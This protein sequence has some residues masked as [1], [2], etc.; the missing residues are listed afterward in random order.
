MRLPWN[1]VRL[2]L[3]P[4]R[5]SFDTADA[6]ETQG[7]EFRLPWAKDRSSST[8]RALSASPI[9]NDDICELPETVARILGESLLFLRHVTLA[10]VRRNG[11]LVASY[12]ATRD[13]ATGRLD[14]DVRPAGRTS[15]WHVLHADA[16]QRMARLCERFATL[17][18]L[19]RST[20]VTVAIPVDQEAGTTGRFFA[21]LPTEQQHG[22][23]AHINADFFPKLD[24]KAIVLDGGQHQQAWN[25]VLIECAAA[26]L[27][28][29]LVALREHLAPTQLWKLISDAY[30]TAERAT[31]GG[32]PPELSAFRKAIEAAL[33]RHPPIAMDTLGAWWPARELLHTRTELEADEVSALRQIGVKLI[34]PSL[35]EY[36]DVLCKAGVSLL[37]ARSLA[38][39][40]EDAPV[41]EELSS[42]GRV[43]S[44]QRRSLLE[45]LWRTMD[46]FL[47]RPTSSNRPLSSAPLF[48]RH[49]HRLA[50]FEQGRRRPEGASLERLAKWFPSLPLPH[51]S[52]EEHIHTLS[53]AE[54]LEPELVVSELENACRP[55]GLTTFL[56]HAEPSELR[57]F[58]RLLRD[59]MVGRTREA[60]PQTLAALAVLPIF[61]SGDGYVAAQDAF[62]PGDF[63]DPVGVASLLAKE[64]YDSV[65]QEFLQVHLGVRKQSIEIYV[66]AQ[67]PI[68]FADPPPVEK[69]K[70]LL[71]VLAD[72]SSSLLAAPNLKSTLREIRMIPVRDGGWAVPDRTYKHTEELEKLIGFGPEWW[73]DEE[74]TPGTRAT[75][76]FLLDLGVRDAPC[77]EHLLRTLDELTDG[78][79]TEEVRKQAENLFYVICDNFSRWEEEDGIDLE[80]LRQYESEP[81]FPADGVDDEWF[82]GE[83]LYTPF[84]SAAFAS[85]AKILPF[86]KTQ[87]LNPNALGF[88]GI[89]SEPT[90]EMVIAHLRH[91]VGEGVAV[92]PVAYRILNERA[93]DPADTALM[94]E[95]RDE[96]CIWSEKDNGYLKPNRLF[97]TAPGLGR[98]GAQ[99]PPRA[100]EYQRFFDAVGVAEQPTPHQYVDIAKQIAGEYGEGRRLDT[101]DVTVMRNCLREIAAA[102]EDPDAELRK[103]ASSLLDCP[104]ILNRAD[105]LSYVHDVAF[106]DSEWHVAPFGDDIVGMLA[107]DD[108][109]IRPLYEHLGVEP[110]SKVVTR[111]ADEVTRQRD[112]PET[113]SRFSERALLFV[114][115]LHDQPVSVRK[116]L[117]LALREL[118]VIECEVLRARHKWSL[119]DNE[120]TSDAQDAMAIFET[121]GSR[122]YIRPSANTPTSSTYAETLR[123]IFHVLLPQAGGH[124]LPK[125]VF[126]GKHLMT[127][128]SIGEAEGELA[129]AGIPELADTWDSAEALPESGTLG[130]FPVVEDSPDCGMEEQPVET[131]EADSASRPKEMDAPPEPAQNGAGQAA[132]RVRPRWGRGKPDL[133]ND[134]REGHPA[135]TRVADPSATE[136]RGS[137]PRSGSGQV[138]RSVGQRRSTTAAANQRRDRLRSYVTARNPGT[139]VPSSASRDPKHRYAVEEA[140]RSIVCEY[141]VKRGRTTEQMPPMHPAYDIKSFDRD[142]NVVRLIEVK[143]IDGEWG[144]LGVGL[145][146][147]QFSEAWDE[148][149]RY[150]LYVVEFARDPERARV[151]P[152]QS[153][154]VK[155]GE[156][157]FDRNWRG[158]AESVEDDLRLAFRAGARMRHRKFG[159][160]TIRERNERGHSVELVID[161]DSGGAKALALN[162]SQME[163]AIGEEAFD[164]DALS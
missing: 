81:I 18:H 57:R 99:V 154:A 82:S 16:A 164:G 6:P 102:I 49:D 9:T 66:E 162:L 122:L 13:V 61:R 48:L 20:K 50:R 156:F 75:D 68:F 34:H 1:G 160:G 58:Y 120:F 116:K 26:T 129:D 14:I 54:E 128:A 133:G 119:G 149:D 98:F 147:R 71:I 53:L 94:K 72:H 12:A 135:A 41:L 130:D 150:W 131:T 5:E 86:R 43:P 145:K 62:L 63:E 107:P 59:L 52:L 140:A 97:W 47:A 27:A 141:E 65:T 112:N 17:S 67:M 74:R 25:A 19:R 30:T 148:G 84:R 73:L 152:I 69:Y 55:D 87:R 144:D 88:F 70:K 153:P 4:E 103:D 60:R 127:A 78:E 118:R 23:S 33:A 31:N 161:F 124:E 92:S 3:L 139:E 29:N 157:F 22:L 32:A 28:E 24:R 100:R 123:S 64:C 8:R 151:H 113:S 46:K 79:P 146:K 106:E 142:G 111:L 96:A 115:L 105:C 91:C 80:W 104:C 56:A 89:E 45:P 37:D 155:V 117:L 44:K 132:D 125:L 95:L 21:Y 134:R 39:A 143:G 42:G 114:R 158:V 136:D 163:L 11:K 35:A 85:Q 126:I 76:A 121:D 83:E 36:S 38:E 93:S 51:P 77:A 159:Q 15:S 2:T 137:E 90:T 138:A 109:D 110:V 108:P 40:L 7:T 10:E 101:D